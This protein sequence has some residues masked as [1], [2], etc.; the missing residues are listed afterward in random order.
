MLIIGQYFPPDLG[1]AATRAYNAAKGLV[2]N[3][4]RVT[5]IT[6]F[7]HYPHGK[8]PKKYRWLPIKVE[9]F[10]RMRVVRTFIL[11]LES[12]GLARRIILFVSFMISSLFALPFVGKID[13]IWAANPDIISLIPALVYG[14]MKRKPVT[15]NVDDLLLKDL[16]DLEFMKEGSTLSKAAELVARMVYGKAKAITPISPG[17][18]D[19]ISKKYHVERRKMYV[20]RGGVDLTVFKPNASHWAGRAKKFRVLYSGAFSVAYDFEQVLKAA[21]IVQE[22]DDGVEFVLQGRGELADTVRSK[23]GELKLKN[24]KVIEKVFSREEVAGLLSLADALILPLKDFGEPYLGMSSKLYEYQGVEKPII[25]CAE[26]QPADYVE[27]TKSGIVVR[28]GDHERLAEVV[29]SLRGDLGRM[30]EMGR[31]GKRHVENY[32]TIKMIGFELK[33]ILSMVRKQ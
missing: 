29:V 27:E 33:K 19:Y 3:G 11:P 30:M 17:Y 1:G 20:V 2:L 15:S 24:V 13:V 12:T 18:V 26:G 10:G 7:P 23:I 6:A 14:K 8:I 21:K 28:P 4:C 32:L 25:C 16:Y 31:R 5:V 22:K 9:H